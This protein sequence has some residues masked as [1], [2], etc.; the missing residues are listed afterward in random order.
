MK[1]AIISDTHSYF[2]E[3]IANN[4]SLCDE[5]WHAGD[6]GDLALFDRLAA[7]KPLRAVYGNIDGHELRSFLPEVQKFSVEG[8]KVIMT[9]IG[10]YPG[11]YEKKV[12]EW[13]LH[14]QADIFI[15]GHS[16]ILKVMPDKAHNLLHINPGAAGK[17]GLHKV[18][19]M[20]IIDISDRKIRDLKVIELGKRGII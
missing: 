9:H 12:R 1:A 6:I 4:C 3:M 19:T 5:I 8:L 15:S 2:D 16:H 11:R 17:Y 18:R 13:L 7:I 14:E 10:G 20:I